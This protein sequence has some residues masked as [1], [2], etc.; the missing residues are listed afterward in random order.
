M[1]FVGRRD[2]VSRWWWPVRAGTGQAR[3]GTSA[4]GELV[5][6]GSVGAG[7]RAAVAGV[8]DRGV[9]VAAALVSR[10]RAGSGLER[11]GRLSLPAGRVAVALSGRC[12]RRRPC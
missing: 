10:W 5:R 12:A 9:W 4:G 2:E 3:G 8:A 6:R 1:G 7:G 11:A